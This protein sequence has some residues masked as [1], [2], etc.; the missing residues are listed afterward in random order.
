MLWLKAF[1]VI[2]VVTWF[3]GLFY[4]P[5]LFVYH[6]AA[7]DAL[8]RERFM[9]MERRLFILMT[10]GGTLAIAFGVSM[11]AAAPG[12][13]SFTWLRV[14]LVLVAGLVLYHLWCYRLIGDLRAGRNS[15]SQ[16]WYRIFNEVPGLFLIAI[17]VLAVVKP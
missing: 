10:V 4:L 14:K 1:H 7:P 5:R 12:Y 2:F 3:A 9:V 8:G 16:R 13:L 11:V 15:R 6:S 17:V